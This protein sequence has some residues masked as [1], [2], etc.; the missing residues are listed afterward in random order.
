MAPTKEDEYI[1][2]IADPQLQTDL[3][4]QRYLKQ[5]VDGAWGDNIAMQAIADMLSVT[6]TVLSSD[7]PA[8]S[9][10]PQ[11]DCSTD[12]L[13]VDLI[14]Q[15]H[16]VGLDKIPEPALPIA[17][18]Q[19]LCD[20][21]EQPDSDNELDDATVAEGD[22]HRIQ[23]SGAPQASMMYVENPESFSHTYVCCP[24]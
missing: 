21:P 24:S 14:M 19:V 5:L 10:T 13:F 1:A 23:I 9:A 17:D 18:K 3:R 22:E 12:E 6:M 2:S 11:T 7:Y 16:Y 8:Y 15:Y 20:K 4:W